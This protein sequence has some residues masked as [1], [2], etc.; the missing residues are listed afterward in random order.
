MQKKKKTQQNKKTKILH[1]FTTDLRKYILM[2]YY[3]IEDLSSGA[4]G[5]VHKVSD[6]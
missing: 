1:Q 6:S 3:N 4:P 2:H 5:S